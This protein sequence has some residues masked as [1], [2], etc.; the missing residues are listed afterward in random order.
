[1]SAERNSFSA[2]PK[3]DQHSTP[4][5][6]EINSCHNSVFTSNVIYN[7]SIRPTKAVATDMRVNSRKR[8]RVFKPY[9]CRP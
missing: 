5:H 4:I 1:M 3:A 8:A 6:S 2:D 7:N 9:L